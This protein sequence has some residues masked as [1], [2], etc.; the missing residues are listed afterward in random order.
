[1]YCDKCGKAKMEY[2]SQ[3]DGIFN[4]YHSND[5]I[6]KVITVLM[7]PDHG[8]NFIIEKMYNILKNNDSKLNKHQ[9]YEIKYKYIHNSPLDYN[10]NNMLVSFKANIPLMN[11]LIRSK[12]I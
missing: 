7:N 10:I 3:G 5:M 1:M 6:N 12:R 2:I 4:K 8:Y 11:N 9:I